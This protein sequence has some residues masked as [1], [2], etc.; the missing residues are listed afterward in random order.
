M[1]Q[2]TSA[3]HATAPRTRNHKL[4]KNA[5][6]SSTPTIRWSSYSHPF[7]SEIA[8]A[9][10]LM[11]RKNLPC[12][13]WESLRAAA[14]PFQA[15]RF[16]TLFTGDVIGLHA[17]LRMLPCRRVS[18]VPS[19]RTRFKPSLLIRFPLFRQSKT[20]FSGQLSTPLDVDDTAERLKGKNRVKV[21]AVQSRPQRPDALNRIVERRRGEADS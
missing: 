2:V 12:W 6:G 19:A 13:C 14:S 11:N 9:Q 8:L 18:R 16:S 20:A 3:R 7:D 21:S 1:I 5:N 4:R 10:Q 17:S 15:P